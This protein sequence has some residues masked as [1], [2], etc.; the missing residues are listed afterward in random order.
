MDGPVSYDCPRIPEAMIAEAKRSFPADRFARE[1]LCEFAQPPTAAFPEEIVRAC[2]DDTLP[3]FFTSPLAY[4]LP[5]AP[6]RAQ[7]HAHMGQDLGECV[8]P[9]VL[10]IAEY[11][12]E[13]T[14]T[15]DP[16]TREPLFRCS[17]ALRHM[18]SPALGT[19]Y[20][21]VAARARQVAQHPRMARARGR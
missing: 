21:D 5:A 10:A 19:P 3:D 7:P 18:E 20:P 14:F 13:P 9:S 1:Y 8:D 17:L 16:A 12:S 6:R 15:V 11:V 4:P 2:L